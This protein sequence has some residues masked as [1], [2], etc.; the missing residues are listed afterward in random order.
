MQFYDAFDSD[1]YGRTWK[2]TKH[3]LEMVIG[4]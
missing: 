4:I 3:P 2:I 1:I